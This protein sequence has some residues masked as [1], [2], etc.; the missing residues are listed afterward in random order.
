M[1]GHKGNEWRAGLWLWV[2]WLPVS[3]SYATHLN[4]APTEDRQHNNHLQLRG[5]C[6]YALWKMSIIIHGLP[7][8]P[9]S[10]AC[11]KKGKKEELKGTGRKKKRNLFK[12]DH[13]WSLIS[14]SHLKRPHSKDSSGRH[15]RLDRL[16]SNG[17]ISILV[18]NLL[19][20][21]QNLKTEALKQVDFCVFK[22]KLE[23][24][25]IFVS[26]SFFNFNIF[27]SKIVRT[28]SMN[29]DISI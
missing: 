3:V 11:P 25:S 15:L 16:G 6:F 8:P 18:E 28:N 13:H 19:E 20:K 9:L 4:Y 26:F 12:F 29:Y 7:L 23:V 10:L 2:I 5:S 21:V 24:P 14:F 22:G 1:Q 17:S 27:F